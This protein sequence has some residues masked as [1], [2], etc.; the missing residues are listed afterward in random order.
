MEQP[1]E[2]NCSRTIMTDSL[3][4]LKALEMV[5][6]SKNSMENKILKMLAEKGES[7]KLIWVPAHKGI[8]G[9]K[10]AD[11]AA[12]YALNENILPGTKSTEMEKMVEECSKGNFRKCHGK[13]WS[14]GHPTN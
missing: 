7:L 1:N 10:A 13:N 9:N 5:F 8:E 6:P 4:S 14:H 12:K 2:T 3:S 11:E